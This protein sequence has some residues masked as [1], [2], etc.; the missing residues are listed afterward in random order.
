V[1]GL[2]Q[3]GLVVGCGYLGQRVARAWRDLGWDVSALTRSGE[4]AKEFAGQGLA[5]CVGD[6]TEPGSLA[7]LSEFAEADVVLFAV[8]RDR[9]RTSQGIREVSLDGLRNVIDVLS[10]GSVRFVFIS[11]TGVYGQSEGEWVDESSAIQ[12]T[13]ENGRVLVESEAMVRSRLGSRGRVLRLAGLY[14][15]SRLIARRDALLAGHPLAGNPEAWLNLVHVDDA[16]RAVVSASTFETVGGDGGTWLVCD[17]RPVQR[18]E[19][20][21]RL[22]E[23][24]GAPPPTFD[25]ARD[26]SRIDGL[27]KR[28]RNQRMKDELRVELQYPDI[29]SGLRAALS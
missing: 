4:R 27:G 23:L 7:G 29:E 19:Y 24:C 22:A 14:G 1:S 5:P 3:R 18:K 20:F 15:P 10:E 16:T 11:S 8:G 28:C 9:E 2:Q 13:R 17:D 26:S 21:G 25:P 6:V 12:P